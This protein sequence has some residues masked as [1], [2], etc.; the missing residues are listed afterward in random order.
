MFCGT[1]ARGFMRTACAGQ[2]LSA[3]GLGSAALGNFVPTCLNP[4]GTI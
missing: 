1:Q 2:Q 3:D 4:F